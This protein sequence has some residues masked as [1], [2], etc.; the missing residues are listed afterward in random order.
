M[1]NFVSPSSGLLPE[2]GSFYSIPSLGA[3]IYSNE[4]VGGAYHNFINK[5]TSHSDIDVELQELRMAINPWG[6]VDYMPP[7]RVF[8]C[9]GKV[10]NTSGLPSTYS[11][12]ILWNEGIWW[13]HIDNLSFISKVF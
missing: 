6:K 4:Y 8:L 5:R 12:P 2:S 7:G 13:L 11:I 1:D 9:T 10:K 3:F